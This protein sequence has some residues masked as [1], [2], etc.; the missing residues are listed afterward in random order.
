MLKQS[1]RKLLKGQYTVEKI[2]SKR[3]QEGEV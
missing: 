3:L 1:K 2:L